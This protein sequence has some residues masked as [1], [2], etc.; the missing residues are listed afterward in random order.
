[1]TTTSANAAHAIAVRSLAYRYSGAAL[2]ALHDINI[3]VPRAEIFGL[4]GPNGAGKSTLLGLLSGSLSLQSGSIIIAGEPL[5]R[6]SRQVKRVSAMVPQEYAFYESLSG[7]Q[8]LDYFGSVFG[9]SSTQREQRALKAV[10]ICRLEED[11]GR[12]AGDYS[13]GLKRRL[14]LAIGLLNEPQI[15]YLDEPTVGIDAQSRRFILDAVLALKAIGTTIVY[16]SHYM[17]EVEQLCDSVAVIDH[18]RVVLQERTANL[19]RREGG[20][21]L[22]ITL[23]DPNVAASDV[24]Q[25]FAATHVD[26]KVWSLLLPPD[27]LPDVLAALARS[28]AR[29]ERLQYGV[30]RLEEIY[31]ELLLG[32]RSAAE[33]AA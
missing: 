8:N 11:I 18:G 17:E 33:R 14:N 26:H 31:L 3:D 1:M 29:V 30:S 19:L 15:L 6:R 5:P 22:Q 7:Q 16:T 23:A 21:R 25:E 27:R 20:Q 4:L 10:E 24:L 28:G 12:I 2:D 9:L 32:S 13:G